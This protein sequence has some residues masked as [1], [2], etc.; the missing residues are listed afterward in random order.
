[1]SC[2]YYSL[3]TP[4]VLPYALLN[5]TFLLSREYLV[6]SPHALPET[7]FAELNYPCSCISAYIR[8]TLMTSLSA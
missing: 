2:F 4:K 8:R 6:L 1:M 7:H 5:T 3:V